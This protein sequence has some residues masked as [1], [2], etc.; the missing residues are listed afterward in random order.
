MGYKSIGKYF[1][2]LFLNRN[3]RKLCKYISLLKMFV[4]R[5]NMLIISREKPLINYRL[6]PMISSITYK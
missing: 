3:I 5:W 6:S 1:Y 4:L 2:S